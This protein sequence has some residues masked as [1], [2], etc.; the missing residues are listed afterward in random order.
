[1]VEFLPQGYSQAYEQYYRQA[2]E[3]PLMRQRA[4]TLRDLYLQ[5]AQRGILRSG[6]GMYPITQLEQNITDILGREGSRLALAQAER[7]SQLE[8]MARQRAFQREMLERQIEFQRQI[9]D[10][11][12]KL[13]EQAVWGQLLGAGIGMVAMPALGAAGGLAADWLTRM[14]A[15]QTYARQQAL[16]SLLQSYLQSYLQQPLGMT[17]SL[18]F[19]ETAGIVNPYNLYPVQTYPGRLTLIGG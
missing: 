12:R 7:Q 16:Q 17:P 9:L 10:E 18:N 5:Q 3:Q 13:A 4:R 14:I 6:V 15:P 8:E 19:S 1:M 11:Q 2:V